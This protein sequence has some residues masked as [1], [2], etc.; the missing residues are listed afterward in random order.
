MT[1]N[2][3]LIASCSIQIKA[4]PEQVWKVLTEPEYVAQFLYGTRVS[5]DWNV[6]SKIA[7]SG[8]Y[9]GQQYEDKGNVLEH[10]QNQLLKYNYWSGMSGLE[11]LEENY[12][13]VTYTVKALDES[14]SEFTWHQAG[15]SS[16]E[17]KCHTEDGLKQMLKTI[18]ALAENA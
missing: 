15:F 10:S 12:A 6:G 11:D 18:K 16:E 9:N 2:K 4:N 17:G 14:N 8:N 5:T 7:F 13:I 1:L 3:S